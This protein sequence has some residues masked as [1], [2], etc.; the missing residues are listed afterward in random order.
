MS[1]SVWEAVWLCICPGEVCICGSRETTKRVCVSSWGGGMGCD[2]VP[3]IVEGQSKADTCVNWPVCVRACMCV[4]VHT[5]TLP[6]IQLS[7]LLRDSRH[8]QGFHSTILDTQTHKALSVFRL[9]HALTFTSHRRLSALIPIKVLSSYLFIYAKTGPLDMHLELSSIFG[10]L[11]ALDIILNLM[12]ANYGLN[13]VT[14][15]CVRFYE[16]FYI[17]YTHCE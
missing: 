14:L 2:S 17:F 4:S 6:L 15:H 12:N 1:L 9:T 16:R 7:K 5:V 11:N 8:W 3:V 10:L 13:W